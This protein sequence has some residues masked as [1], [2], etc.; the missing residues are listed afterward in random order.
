MKLCRLFY[1]CWSLIQW[2]PQ[3]F[4][5]SPTTPLSIFCISIRRIVKCYF[6]FYHII[7]KG[8]DVPAGSPKIKT[9]SKDDEASLYIFPPENSTSLI[10]KQITISRWLFLYP[11]T[12]ILARCRD[13]RLFAYMILRHSSPKFWDG[14]VLGSFNPDI[15]EWGFRS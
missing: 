3:G 9:F 11:K 10:W 15:R 6:I 14:F 12:L 8:I 13:I 4:S 2:L 1:L 5:C 7:L